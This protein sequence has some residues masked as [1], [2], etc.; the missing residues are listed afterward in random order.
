M[1]TQPVKRNKDYDV[2]LATLST[3]VRA[4]G[5]IKKSKQ[6]NNTKM[7]TQIFY[8]EPSVKKCFVVM[9]GLFL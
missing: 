6:I 1:Y 8:S 5:F 2:L 9:R 7:K 3:T 4:M